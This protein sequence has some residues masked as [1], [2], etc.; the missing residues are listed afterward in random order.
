VWLIGAVVCLLAANRNSSRSLTRAMDDRI[1]RC[2]I[3]SSCQSAATSEIVKRLEG[4][5]SV[6]CKKRYSKHV[7]NFTFLHF[8]GHH[9]QASSR[10]QR[11]HHVPV[12]VDNRLYDLQLA[13]CPT[14]S[15]FPA[16][17]LQEWAE[18]RGYGLRQAAAY[19]LVCLHV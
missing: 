10:R 12:V 17:S 5:E 3:T 18:Y 8:R 2:G 6:S 1:V 16:T 13:D 19:I 14:I 7:S 11:Y 9:Q 15:H 4:L